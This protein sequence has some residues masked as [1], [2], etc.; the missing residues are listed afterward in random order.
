MSEETTEV[1]DLPPYRQPKP[2]SKS[3]PTLY[4]VIIVF[5][6]SLIVAIL[7]MILGELSETNDKL[8]EAG[9]TL[10]SIEQHTR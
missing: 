4:Q 2:K 6:L 1:S 10:D 3:N 5:I 7:S 9:R 8:Y